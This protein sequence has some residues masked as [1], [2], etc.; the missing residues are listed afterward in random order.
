MLIH[1]QQL[2]GC[3]MKLRTLFVLSILFLTHAA[4]PLPSPYEF[5]WAAVHPVAAVKV[6]LISKRCQEHLSASGYVPPDQY[7]NGGLSDA[8]R[9]TFYMAAFAQKIKPKKLRKLGLAHEKGN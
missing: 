5:I 9:H 4:W 8:F 3:R 1:S 7:P 6:K 2:T